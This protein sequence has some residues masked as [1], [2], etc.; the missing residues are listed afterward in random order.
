MNPAEH[1]DAEVHLSVAENA[2]TM[3]DRRDHVP[4]DPRYFEKEG[5]EVQRSMAQV[6]GHIHETR[7]WGH[8]DS[9]SGEGSTELQTAT[10]RRELPLLLENLGVR[11]LLDIPCGDFAWLSQVELAL[12]S[13]VGGDIVPEIIQRNRER[14]PSPSRTFAVLDLSRDPIPAGDLLLCRDCLVHFSFADINRTFENLAEGDV[15]YLLTTTF[16]DCKENEDITTG[17]WRP[18]NLQLPPFNFPPPLQ[19]IQENSTEGGG[20]FVDKSLGLW[21]VADIG[22]RGTTQ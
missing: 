19:L 2:S 10:L 11:V 22:A 13:Y 12:S 7:H 6:F 3:P 9:V 1:V 15:G 17:D 5:A 21:R 14:F 4:F 18:I 20:I 16:T 8:P